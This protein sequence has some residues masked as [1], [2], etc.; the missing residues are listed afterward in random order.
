MYNRREKFKN[1][2]TLNKKQMSDLSKIAIIKQK[3][4]SSF[5]A[6]SEARMLLSEIT[7]EIASVSNEDLLAN[8]QSKS[9]TGDEGERIVEGVFNGVEMIDGEENVYPV[10]VNYASKS[11]LVT[12]DSLKLTIRQDGRFLYKQIGPVPRKYIMG[13]LSYEEGKYTVLSEGNV[14]KVLLASVTYFK[15]KIGDEVTILIPD[16]QETEWAAIDAVLPSM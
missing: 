8:A 12:G 13:P 7:G 14:Y 2:Y 16:G 1:K 10:P 5:V 9:Y 15:A 4:D 11:K 3:I 6:L